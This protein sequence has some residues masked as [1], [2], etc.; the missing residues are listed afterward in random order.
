L[1]LFDLHRPPLTTH[2]TGLGAGFPDTP[3]ARE[4][5]R[6]PLVLGAWNGDGMHIECIEGQ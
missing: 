3:D 1:D 2:P 5:I 4:S 6:V